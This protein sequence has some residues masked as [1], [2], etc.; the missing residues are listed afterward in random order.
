MQINA[1]LYSKDSFK[2]PKKWA[3]EWKS[4]YLQNAQSSFLMSLDVCIF[5]ILDQF[6]R[7]H[8][9]RHLMNIISWKFMSVS[10]VVVGHAD[11]QRQTCLR[12][13]RYAATIG[14]LWAH[15]KTFKQVESFK[16]HTLCK[17]RDHSLLHLLNC[18]IE[19]CWSCKHTSNNRLV[20][21]TLLNSP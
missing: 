7:R 21:S 6:Q 3:V 4:D 8:T 5:R 15:I 12:A 11:R 9:D 2:Y 20:D 17:E 10:L 18:S 13:Y 19:E 14:N 1:R 16:M